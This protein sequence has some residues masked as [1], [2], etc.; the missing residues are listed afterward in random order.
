MPAAGAMRHLGRR[1]SKA[2]KEFSKVIPEEASS[3]DWTSVL[4]KA[5]PASRGG[6]LS[7]RNTGPAGLLAAPPAA[8]PRQRPA[9]S[10][11]AASLQRPPPVLSG[12]GTV[13]R[14]RTDAPAA[15]GQ[16]EG[17]YGASSESFG[18]YQ[19]VANCAHMLTKLV[20]LSSGPQ[21]VDWQLN[22]RGGVGRKPEDGWRRYFQR[23]ASSFD[24]RRDK[25]GAAS[26]TYRSS[27]VTPEERK[28]D[29]HRGAV[30]VA[31]LREDPINLQ[32]EAGCEGTEVGQW[33]HLLRDTSSGTKARSQLIFET[34]L[35]ELPGDDSGTRITDNRTNGC[36]VEMLGKKKWHDAGSHEPLRLHPAKG[37][38]IKLH[39][40][41]FLRPE[42]E[43]DEEN[44]ALRMARHPRRDAAAILEAAQSKTSG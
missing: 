37:G 31:G 33:L 28:P 12:D 22:L 34:T 11:A 7:G 4:K 26:E 42:L 18:R 14:Y 5:S 32:R 27:S 6:K 13:R 10:P 21:A 2:A 35:R 29:R 43:R 39:H 41:N 38:D 30:K 8:A 17:P 20:R 15:S 36:I 3:G 16:P 44:R 19:N 40:L 9:R 25:G 24:V 23:P 1:G